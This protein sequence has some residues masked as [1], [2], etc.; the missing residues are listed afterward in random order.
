MSKAGAVAMVDAL[1]KALIANG[2]Q[3]V[4]SLVSK[5]TTKAGQGWESG[6]F[7][8]K[9]ELKSSAVFLPLEDVSPQIPGDSV[10]PGNET[11]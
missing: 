10:F 4:L 2:E 11:E 1:G 9:N 6:R 5:V 7:Q 3:N 8:R